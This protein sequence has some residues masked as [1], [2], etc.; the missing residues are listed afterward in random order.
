MSILNVVCAIIETEGIIL[1]TQRSGEMK[2]AYKWEF[3][4]GKLLDT[5]SEEDGLIREI[6]EE[7]NLIIEPKIRL[8]VVQHRYK[9]VIINLIPYIAQIKSGDLKL[10]EH[11]AVA[12]LE[13]K[14]L[15]SLDLLEADIEIVE[16]LQRFYLKKEDMKEAK[17]LIK[18]I[19]L[20]LG[21]SP[22]S[23]RYSYM[24]VQRL[25]AYHYPVIAL[26]F[27][28]D[29]IEDIP[30]V[31]EKKIYENIHT[32]TLYLSAKNQIDFYDYILALNPK[33][34][35]FNPGTENLE[36]YQILDKAEIEYFEACTLVMLNTGQYD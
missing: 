6:K 21:A 23:D 22:K 30:I 25:K 20:V 29:M 31:T 35:I 24:A 33:R 16:Q 15:S 10:K 18:N 2:H 4:G 9:D 7:L 28:E 5:E 27:K 13:V 12:L 36:F 17:E 8:H 1:V 11:N 14:E 26:G 19:T 32:V 3:P 34:V